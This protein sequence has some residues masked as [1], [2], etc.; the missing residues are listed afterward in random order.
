MRGRFSVESETWG[1]WVMLILLTVSPRPPN[2]DEIVRET[3][4]IRDNLHQ[5]SRTRSSST[6]ALPDISMKTS[7][8][9]EPY[10]EPFPGFDVEL[11]YQRMAYPYKI[12]APDRPE[13]PPRVSRSD[14]VPIRSRLPLK[15]VSRTH[16]RRTKSQKH[17]V[18][19]QSYYLPDRDADVYV[20][21]S[22]A[23]PRR[24]RAER[25][26]PTPADDD[27]SQFYSSRRVIF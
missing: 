14:T 22:Y 2:Y 10:I 8:H 18:A 11:D 13:S 1:S 3:S 15:R 6:E 21:R 5:P 24:P 17:A 20:N 16:T 12:Q 26:S 9:P 25:G 23:G 19:D 4:K 7:P 27:D